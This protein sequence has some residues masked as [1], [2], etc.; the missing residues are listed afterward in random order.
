MHGVD[1]RRDNNLTYEES[2]TAYNSQMSLS[3]A[4]FERR[5]SKEEIRPEEHYLVIYPEDYSDLSL[6]ANGYYEAAVFLMDVLLKKGTSP[7]HDSFVFPILY[8]LIHAFEL[9]LKIYLKRLYYHYQKKSCTHMPK[10]CPDISNILG[11]HELAPIYDAIYKMVDHDQLHGNQQIKELRPLINNIEELGLSNE[12]LRYYEIKGKAKN[13]LLEQQ[14][15]VYLGQLK[16]VFKAAI[17]ILESSYRSLDFEYCEWHEFKNAQLQ[18]IDYMVHI[19]K[20]IKSNSGFMPLERKES[21]ELFVDLSAEDLGNT[22]L[23]HIEN[24]RVI[25]AYIK[26]FDS[27]KLLLA[28][29]GIRFGKSD[30]SC[31]PDKNWIKSEWDREKQIDYLSEDFSLVDCAIENLTKH[32]AYIESRIKI[33]PA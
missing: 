17:D 10:P 13:K 26:N 25:E 27:N 20:D 29:R 15:W 18:E 24:K 3:Q 32:K 28:N 16:K 22:F 21:K 9:H 5:R 31:V 30:P 4:I 8:N 14:R 7:S 1:S 12:S 33:K 2:T 23:R 19:L 11:K 6:Y